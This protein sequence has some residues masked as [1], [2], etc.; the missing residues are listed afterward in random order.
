V[1]RQN[2]TPATAHIIGQQVHQL[3]GVDRCIGNGEGPYD[4]TAYIWFLRHDQIGVQL[5]D[6]NFGVLA[7]GEKFVA[8][9]WRV[10]RQRNKQTPSPLNRFRGKARDDPAFAHTFS[11][12]IRIAD[13]IARAALQHA[14]KAAAGTGTQITKLDKGDTESPQN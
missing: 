8:E 2:L 14:V 6:R 13:G 11:A 10:V 3:P 4:M 9:P 12:I 5:I 1:A 7:S